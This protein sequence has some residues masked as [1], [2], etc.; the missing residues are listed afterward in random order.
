[1]MSTILIESDRLLL[2]TPRI[3]FLEKRLKEKGFHEKISINGVIEEIFFPSDWPGDAL[4][5]YP[6][7]IERRRKDPDILPYWTYNIIDKKNKTVVGD[8]CCKSKPDEKNEIEIG[9]G[10]NISHHGKG[11]ATEAVLSLS[12]YLFSN[13]NVNTIKA[14]SN[15]SNIPSIKVLEKCGFIKV[16]RRFD[17]EDGHLIIWK[18]FKEK[19]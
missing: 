15:K 19:L 16:G 12:L 8:I 10:I 1:M 17:S 18:K 13:T 4:K 5:I 9:Y 2:L 6:F 11:Y 7:E 3:E 14:E